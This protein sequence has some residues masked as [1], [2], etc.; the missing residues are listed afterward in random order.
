[1]KLI[2]YSDAPFVLNKTMVYEN[3]CF[4]MDS[5]GP[6]PN[7]LWVSVED[8]WKNW[9]LDELFYLEYIKHCSEV[10]IKPDANI[11]TMSTEEELFSFSDKYPIEASYFSGLGYVDW[12][13]VTKDY[14]GVIIAPY[15]WG[16]RNN[17]K[18]MWYYGWDVASGCIW[19]LAC[20]EG[21]YL[22]DYSCS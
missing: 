8:A 10:V 14:G 20:I 11:L 21:V 13:A 16:C 9:C 18:S 12:S 6:K 4:G 15:L 2:H 3:R 19:D 22:M 7:G 17:Q 1:M 5:S